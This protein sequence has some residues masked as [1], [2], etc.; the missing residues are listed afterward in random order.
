[1]EHHRHLFG[2]AAQCGLIGQQIGA[3]H[4]QVDQALAQ[5]GTCGFR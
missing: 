1:M 4:R 5:L 2:H 3:D